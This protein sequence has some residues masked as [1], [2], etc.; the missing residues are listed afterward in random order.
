MFP[1]TELP[2]DLDTIEIPLVDRG[3]PHLVRFA[4]QRER[5]SE[6]AAT[7]QDEIL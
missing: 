4:D 6:G 5:P 3:E 7:L 2:R 1:A